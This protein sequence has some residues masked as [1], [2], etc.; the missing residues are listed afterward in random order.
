MSTAL[1]R[2]IAYKR[3]E[4]ALLKQNRSEQSLLGDALLQNKPRGFAKRL[5]DIAETGENAL[6]CEMKR[7]SPSAGE[8]LPG[9]DPNEIAAQYERGGAAC[10]PVHLPAA[11]RHVDLRLRQRSGPE[12]HA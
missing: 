5:S 2:I 8:I 9:A 6:I 12:Q 3:E 1:D 4:V 7:K 10:R 11:W